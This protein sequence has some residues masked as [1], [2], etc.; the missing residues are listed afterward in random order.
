METEHLA[1]LVRRR[2]RRGDHRPGHGDAKE[3]ERII[4]SLPTGILIGLV[5]LTAIGDTVNIASRLQ[6]V[7]AAGEVLVTEEMAALAVE[8]FRNLES[9]VVML[10]GKERPM[11]VRVLRGLR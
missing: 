11:T 2:R 10:K 4:H 7:A 9:R 1:H 8:N 5:D 6:S 3:R